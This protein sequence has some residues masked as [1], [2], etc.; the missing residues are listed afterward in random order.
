VAVT[1]AGPNG[2]QGQVPSMRK[3]DAQVQHSA[4]AHASMSVVTNTK[5]RKCMGQAHDSMH[6]TWQ[7]ASGH[8][9]AGAI[10][11]NSVT[12]GIQRWQLQSRQRGSTP[13]PF[14]KP[15]ALS[16]NEHCRGV[17]HATSL[18]V[19]AIEHMHHCHQQGCASHVRPQR[20]AHH[21]KDSQRST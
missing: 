20:L 14:L 5:H 12:V 8:C 4:A 1:T 10:T 6:V 7:A 21:Q 9:P 11:V 18:C 19:P 3:C 2:S 17:Q 13:C 16:L 15:S